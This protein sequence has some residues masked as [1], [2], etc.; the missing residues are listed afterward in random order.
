M[1]ELVLIIGICVRHDFMNCF[2]R[3]QGNA[4][5]ILLMLL[6]ATLVA[7]GQLSW[8]L[9]VDADYFWLSIGTIL[10]IGGAVLMLLSFKSGELSVLHPIMS[11]SYVLALVLGFIVLNEP[12]SIAKLSG[13]LL[14]IAG[15]CCLGG[16]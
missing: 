3:L 10:Y 4:K 13:V 12:L 8:K 6:A 14:I 7:F 9:G 1:V 16:G 5:G 15:I 11:F 2:H